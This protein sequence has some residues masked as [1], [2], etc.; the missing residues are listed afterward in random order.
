MPD[1]RQGTGD[2]V[3]NNTEKEHSYSRDAWNRVMGEADE[4]PISK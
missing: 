1:T 4:N 2:T 3:V